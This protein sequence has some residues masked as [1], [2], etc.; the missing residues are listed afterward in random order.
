MRVH[1]VERG[2]W[3]SKGGRRDNVLGDQ[4]LRGQNEGQGGRG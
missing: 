3:V 4:C 1:W 2:V